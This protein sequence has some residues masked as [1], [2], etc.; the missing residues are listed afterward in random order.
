MMKYC[1]WCGQPLADPK[2]PF[3]GECGRQ[4]ATG[5]EKE[6]ASPPPS[7]QREE[8]DPFARQWRQFEEEFSSRKQAARRA[9][10]PTDRE[11]KGPL[12]F[13]QEPPREADEEDRP[14][15][16]PSPTDQDLE[17]PLIFQREEPAPP[18]EPVSPPPAREFKLDL[19]QEL[20]ED[21][22]QPLHKKLS[23]KTK[24]KRTVVTGGR[25]RPGEEEPRE[26]ERR[27]VSPAAVI[28]VGVLVVALATAGI[29]LFHTLSVKKAEQAAVDFASALAQSDLTYLEDRLAK[30]DATLWEEGVLEGICQDLNATVPQKTVENHLKAMGNSS[31]LGYNSQLSALTVVRSGSLLTAKYYLEIQMIPVTILTDLEGL[32]FQVDG[33]ET[34]AQAAE[35]GYSLLVPPGS[36]K[37]EAFG[38][39]SGSQQSMGSAQVSTFAAQPVTLSGFAND[40]SALRIELAG[41][42]TNLS[43]L[44]NGV[45]SAIKPQRGM[46]VVSPVSKGTV[47]TVKCDQYTQDFTVQSDGGEKT[48]VELVENPAATDDPAQMTNR[49]LIEEI[50]P[51]YYAFY[52]S[53]LEATN[54]WD[55]SLIVQVYQGYRD[56]LV[57]RMET[58]NAGLTFKLLELSVD[59]ES[60]V[61]GTMDG[62]MTVSF[63]I[64]TTTN[65]QYKD[66]EDKQ[67]YA[68][69]NLQEIIMRYNQEEDQW[70]TAYSRIDDSIVMSDD[71]ITF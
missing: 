51:Q 39:L 37:V 34:P 21:D 3:C 69:G 7:R 10:S 57:E 43:V 33:R 29:I 66:K 38:E 59:R 14:A 65:Y 25:P 45:E 48:Q 56:E 60:V 61:R 24:K 26:K 52:T 15:A 23:P 42:E 49:Q 35:G 70:E 4:I 11:L 47:V 5:R 46:L 58:Y 9:P 27:P 50:A 8:D 16:G 71:L 17:E 28:L 19:P 20:L 63:Y 62:A 54:Q 44:V 12:I 41:T 31:K 32:T 13:G 68:G 67:W 30:P 64:Q 22:P 53:Y 1:P 18:A 55:D 2:A 40:D 36:S 6:P